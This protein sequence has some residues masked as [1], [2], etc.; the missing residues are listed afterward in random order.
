MTHHLEANIHFSRGNHTLAAQLRV[1]RGEVVAILGPNGAGKST[2]LHVLAGLLRPRFGSIHLAGK[3][4]QGEGA[5]VA[6][7]HRR[8]GLLG[9]DPMLFPHL[10]AANNIS[11]GP[12]AR[13]ASRPQA[14]AIAHEWLKKLDMTEFAHRRPT[15]LS[16]GQRQRIAL[17]RALAADPQLLLLDE[18]LIALDTRSAA[19]IRQLLATH[20][21]E[22]AI[23]TLLVTHDVVDA[24][25]L[26]D[27][28]L[29][30]DAG[31][32]VES[33]PITRVLTAPT[34]PFT[35]AFSGV[36]L[37]AGTSQ[38]IAPGGG[39]GIVTAPP[40]LRVHGITSAALASGTPTTAVFAPAA[41]SVYTTPPGTGSPRNSWPARIID[42]TPS[43]GGA[44]VRAELTD[45][46][47]NAE[48]VVVAAD[49]T[50]AAV[51]ELAL[52]PGTRVHLLVKASEVQ[53]Y[54][55]PPNSEFA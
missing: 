14:R 22:S 15:Q 54:P 26:T 36:N 55:G 12:R 42:V 3:T 13:G 11:F 10:S 50:A 25:T 31:A 28:A 37:I 34:H 39:S 44:R 51:S 23:T 19:Q 2:L 9:Q 1:N 48:P 21:R 5:W 38:T 49:L 52:H 16:G 33:G 47:V 53:L 18:P 24:A 4:L 35:A 41:V 29:I 43:P 32:T 20:I 7:E 27:T 45:S 30:L 8:I 17:A 46:K 40:S 6:P